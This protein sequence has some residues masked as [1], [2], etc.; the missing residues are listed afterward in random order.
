MYE[1]WDMKG[2]LLTI[3]TVAIVT[4]LSLSARADLPMTITKVMDHNVFTLQVPDIGTG[5]PA[6]GGRLRI[7]DVHIAKMVEVTDF[8]CTEGRLEAARP[9]NW[10]YFAGG[11]RTQ[12]GTFQLTCGLARDLAIAY[13]MGKSEPTTV[14][15]FYRQKARQVDPKVLEIPTLN[16]RGDGKIT[17]W[18]RFTNNFK[19][20]VPPQNDR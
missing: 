17:S 9:V 20:I 10:R 3:G 14:D 7:Y 19:P 16:I 2:S 5:K 11:G 13:G 15:E 1:D 8:Y 4:G 18:L 12:M 6:Y